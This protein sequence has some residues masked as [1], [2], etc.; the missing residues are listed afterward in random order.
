V[1]NLKQSCFTILVI[2]INN[3][4][5]ESHRKNV[6]LKRKLINL[7]RRDDVYCN[8]IAQFQ[9]VC[10]IIR[11]NRPSSIIYYATE[12]NFRAI[13]EFSSKPYTRRKGTKI[14]NITR[15]I[16]V[17]LMRFLCRIFRCSALNYEQRPWTSPIHSCTPACPY[18]LAW[19]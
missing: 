3:L 13:C 11:Q 1:Y 19:P 10:N 8:V 7:T 16:F 14:A 4:K 15:Q 9:V 5:S 18:S 12:F 17:W 2:F 6:N